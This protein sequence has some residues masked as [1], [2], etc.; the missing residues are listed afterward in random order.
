MYNPYTLEIFIRILA[1]GADL[2]LKS[3]NS[4]YGN[5]DHEPLTIYRDIMKKIVLEFN[6]RFEHQDND[7]DSFLIYED[8]VTDLIDFRYNVPNNPYPEYSK[9]QMNKFFLM[10]FKYLS[11]MLHFVFHKMNYIIPDEDTVYVSRHIQ[12]INLSFL[13]VFPSEKTNAL[14]PFIGFGLGF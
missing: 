2:T 11:K 3:R 8:T 10:K 14:K 13:Q 9:H 5:F 7:E 1:L 12:F 4:R 6:M